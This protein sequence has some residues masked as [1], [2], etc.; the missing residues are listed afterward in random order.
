MAEST[1]PSSS[2]VSAAREWIWFA[3]WAGFGCLASLAATSFFLALAP[4]LAAAAIAATPPGIRRNA[5]GL[6]AGAAYIP[7]WVA[8]VNRQGP[9]IVRWHTAT[10]SGW[11][12]ESDPKPWLVAGVTM[13]AVAVAGQ[14]LIHR[15][16]R[17]RGAEPVRPR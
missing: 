17:R 4:L 13:I 16:L 15:F 7:L 3:A 12:T 10:S 8:W 6:L 9:G 11:Q 5:F 2:N 1:A 14:L